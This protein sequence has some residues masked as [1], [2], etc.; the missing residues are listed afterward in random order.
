MGFSTVRFFVFVCVLAA[1]CLAIGCR[2]NSSQKENVK[3]INLFDLKNANT[4]K[5]EPLSRD[6]ELAKRLSEGIQQGVNPEKKENSRVLWHYGIILICIA[7]VIAGLV[8]WQVW[9]KKRAEWEQ[10]DPMALVKELNFVHQLSEQEKRV[11]QEISE[12]NALLTPL[13]LF[14]EPKFLLEALESDSFVAVYPSVRRL[15]AKLFDITDGGE[16]APSGINPTAKNFL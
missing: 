15:L 3:G 13:N 1:L 9:Q 11:M 8:Y 14:V 2:D 10:N 4:K 6:N 5:G 16:N 7:I 12:K